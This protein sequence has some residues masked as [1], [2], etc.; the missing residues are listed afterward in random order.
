MEQK[1][2]NASSQMTNAIEDLK[3]N[4]NELKE[5]WA[6]HSGRWD[7]TEENL[8]KVLNKVNEHI[9]ANQERYMEQMTKLDTSFNSSLGSLSETIEELSDL[10]KKTN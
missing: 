4:M 6:K 1:V 10:V 3:G 2:T 8:G 9:Q 5:F 7:E